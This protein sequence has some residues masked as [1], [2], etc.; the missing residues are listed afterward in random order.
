[1]LDVFEHARIGEEAM[2]AIGGGSALGQ[3]GLGLLQI[4]LDTVGVVLGQQRIVK[5]ARV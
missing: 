3:P 1:M 5:A 4:E 2:N